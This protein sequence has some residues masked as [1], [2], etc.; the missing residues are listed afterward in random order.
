MILYDYYYDTGM[1]NSGIRVVY[2]VAHLLE[3]QGRVD[4]MDLRILPRETSATS[5]VK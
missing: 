2:E 5:T 1:Y 3:K 4:L